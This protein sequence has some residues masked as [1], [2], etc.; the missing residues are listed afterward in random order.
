MINA[1]QPAL[2]Q[3]LRR[4]VAFEFGWPGYRTEKRVPMT[5]AQRADLHGRYP[6]NAEQFIRVNAAGDDL[7]FEYGGEEALFLTPVGD[8]RFVATT[9]GLSIELGRDAADVAQLSFVYP[10]GRRE[11]HTRYR[12]NERS[13]RERVYADDASVVDDYRKLAASGDVVAS[14]AYL[15]TQGY[16][17]I[18]QKRYPAAVQV[19]AL[20]T[21]LFPASGNAWDSLGEASLL[22]GDRA[23]ARRRS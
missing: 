14:E 7:S 13:L 3:E 2:M 23:A 21:Q 12:D 18:G 5:A 22:A 15:N 1:N 19:L 6:Y 9:T 10:D 8:G 11:S 17:L 16:R 20:V 4:A